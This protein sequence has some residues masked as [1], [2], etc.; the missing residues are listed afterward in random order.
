[1]TSS[2]AFQLNSVVTKNQRESPRM[3]AVTTRSKPNRSLIEEYLDQRRA[4]L[5]HAVSLQK[6]EDGKLRYLAAAGFITAL[7]LP[8]SSSALRTC[9]NSL[10]SALS[11]CGNFRSSFSSAVTMVAPNTPRANHLSTSGP[12]CHGA[13]ALEVCRM[14]S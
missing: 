3:R 2:L 10:R 6:T 9:L 8:S 13:T 4:Y 1:M 5:D 14:V 11:T 7:P 12:T